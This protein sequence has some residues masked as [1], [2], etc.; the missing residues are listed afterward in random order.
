M[1]GCTPPHWGWQGDPPLPAT[2]Q[3]PKWGPHPRSWAGGCQGVG[4]TDVLAAPQHMYPSVSP[5]VGVYGALTQKTC[6]GRIVARLGEGSN[7]TG[8]LSAD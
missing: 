2:N 8:V 3:G 5:S 6:D 7:R 1:Q 4:G